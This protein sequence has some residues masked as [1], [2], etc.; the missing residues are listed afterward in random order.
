[1]SSSLLLGGPTN[2]VEITAPL[3]VSLERLNSLLADLG[4]SPLAEREYAPRSS[5]VQKC[6]N[7]SRAP[8]GQGV[9]IYQVTSSRIYQFEKGG[10]M[11]QNSARWNRLASSLHRV[12][13]LRAAA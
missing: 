13:A 2:G 6:E 11:D 5:G 1:V 10:V 8:V 3:A 9:T 4:E 7:L 12:D